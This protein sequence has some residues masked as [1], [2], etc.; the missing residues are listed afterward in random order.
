M[1]ASL[2]ISSAF[3]ENVCTYPLLLR[4]QEANGFNSS[5]VEEATKIL[6]RFILVKIIS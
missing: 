1:I 3:I 4:V 5:V 6:H 2:I